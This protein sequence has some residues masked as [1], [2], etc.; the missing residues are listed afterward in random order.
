MSSVRQSWV[1]WRS[2]TSDSIRVARGELRASSYE[3]KHILSIWL[4]GQVPQGKVRSCEQPHEHA[5]AYLLQLTS[6]FVNRSYC[7]W[8]PTDASLLPLLTSY[9]HRP[10]TVAGLLPLPA[11]YC[12]W[13]PTVTGLLLSLASYHCQPPTFII[14]VLLPSLSSYRCCPPTVAGLSSSEYTLAA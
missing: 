7:H 9:R 8:P 5:F 11:S 14:A 1:T 10:P 4:W 2:L 6:S 3:R 12:H 13:P